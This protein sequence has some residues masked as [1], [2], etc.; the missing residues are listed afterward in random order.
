MGRALGAEHAEADPLLRPSGNAK[1]G[2]FQA[3]AAMGLG[4]RLGR[5]PREVAERIVVEL[6]LE[7]LCEPAEV[8][9]PGFI[10]L[11]LTGEALERGAAALVGDAQMGIARAHE[12]Q[13]VVVDYSSPNVAKEMHVGHLRST[14][15]GDAIVRVQEAVGHEVI[16]QNHVGDWGTQFGMLVEH[17]VDIGATGE[18]AH[19]ADLNAFYQEAKKRF[20]ADADFNGRARER[21]VALQ[22]G[23]AETLGL[24]QKLVDESLLHMD[25]VYARL[26]VLLT[27]GDVRGESSYNDGLGGVIEALEAKGLLEESEG[28]KVVFPAGFEGQDGEPMPVIVQKGDGGF[29]YSTTDLAALRYRVSELDVDRIIYVTDARQKQHFAMMLAAGEMAGFVDERVRTDHVTFGM[30]L[31]EDGKP[32]KTRDG[33]TVR[34][35]SLLEEAEERAGA[36]VAEKNPGLSEAEMGRVARVV[37]IGAIKYADLSGDRVK[38]YVFS[39]ERMLAMEGNT[40]PYLL[41]AY[42]RIRGIFRKAALEGAPEG[43][44]V[45]VGHE[46]ERALLLKLMELGS[47]VERVSESLEPHQLCGYLYDLATAFHRFYEHCPVLVAEDAATRDGRLV[48]CEL[49]GRGLKLVLGL[50]GIDVLERM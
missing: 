28:A 49:T 35:M 7:G 33:G 32:F 48:L 24:W 16:R 34:L 46:A 45:S 44:V 12:P 30:V 26:G 19:I 39:W 23:D 11:R 37:G 18:G 38:D 2:D 40:A 42:V 27:E 9:G 43:A 17:L 47:V 20:D 15:I 22:G 25:E 50:L 36:I 4:K 31:G 5:P 14:I 29:L 41:N 13:R 10:N 1:F 21:V 6:D 8:A 3:N